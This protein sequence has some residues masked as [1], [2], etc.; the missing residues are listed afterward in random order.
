MLLPWIGWPSFVVLAAW[1]A[2]LA[3]AEPDNY[4]GTDNC[5]ELLGA[6][7]RSTS[8]EIK[9]AYRKMA[10]KWHPDRNKEPEAEE[11]FKKIARANEVLSND[12]LRAAYDYMLDHPEEELYNT[13]QYY[14]A[15]YKPKTPL[16]IVFTGAVSFISILQYINMHRRYQ[17]TVRYIKKQA[18]FKR[19]VNEVLDERVRKKKKV[20]KDEKAEL[21]EEIENELIGTEVNIVGGSG[22]PSLTS[23]FAFQVVTCPVRA[24][25]GALE[26]S[27]WH[28]RFTLM[29]EEYGDKERIVL[30]RRAI[31]FDDASWNDM[32][33][34]LQ[35]EV[36]K[37]ELWK[38]A[39]YE[40]FQREES[41]AW[42]RGKR[43]LLEK[44]RRANRIVTQDDYED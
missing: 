13:Y 7:R 38:P 25:R 41:E 31:N 36:V 17:T 10:L 28:W 29:G 11:M 16:W 8:D 15:V 23:L 22:K 12:R 30:T 19:R 32:P 20:S 18:S 43:G 21:R 44:Y 26:F 34:H 24:S 2:R 37:R 6:N 33:E 5:Y 42:D 1:F 27:R 40:K 39:N 3:A 9:K 4:C 35:A 14:E